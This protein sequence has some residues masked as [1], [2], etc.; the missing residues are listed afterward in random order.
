MIFCNGTRFQNIHKF[1]NYYHEQ[2]IY[3]LLLNLKRIWIY[4]FQYIYT[5]TNIQDIIVMEKEATALVAIQ[6]ANR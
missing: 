1:F 4:I 5:F 2:E 3:F 6:A